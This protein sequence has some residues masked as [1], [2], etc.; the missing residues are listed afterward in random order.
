MAVV[1]FYLLNGH[2]LTAADDEI[3]ALMLDIAEGL[4]DVEAIAGTLKDWAHPVVL[5]EEET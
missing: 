2:W 4:L 5:L 3:V 1:R